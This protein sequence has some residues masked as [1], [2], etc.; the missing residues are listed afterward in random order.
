MDTHEIIQPLND[1]R[2]WVK[3]V[4]VF[5]IVCGVL[6]CLSIVGLIIGWLPIWLGLAL[7]HVSNN[8]EKYETSNDIAAAIIDFEKLALSFKILGIIIVIFWGLF[9]V[10]IVLSIVFTFFGLGTF[11]MA[12]TE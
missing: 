10:G 6:T 8:L 1:N 4:G 5:S 11:T 12:M 3:V 9:L 7:V 2:I